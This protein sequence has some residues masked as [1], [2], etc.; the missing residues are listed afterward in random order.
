MKGG[1]FIF[2]LFF[3]GKSKETLGLTS[4]LFSGALFE[5]EPSLDSWI[6]A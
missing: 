4:I 5:I 6:V 1:F 3:Y 2:Y